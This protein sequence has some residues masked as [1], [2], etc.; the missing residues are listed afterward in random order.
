MKRTAVVA[1]VVATSMA[2]LA[3]VAYAVFPD[4]DVENYTGCLNAGGSSVG[5]IVNVAVGDAPS[6][7]CGHNQKVIHLGGGDI[8][9]TRTASGSGLKGGTENGAASLALDDTGCG[10]GGVLKW[11]GTGWQCGTDSDTTYSAGTGLDLTGSTFSVKSSFQLPQSCSSGQLTRWSG[12]DQ[13]WVCSEEKSQR[14][15]FAHVASDGALENSFGVA[16]ASRIAVGTYRVEFKGEITSC[17]ATVSAGAA[18]GGSFAPTAVGTV[19]I[20]TG[21][22]SGLAVAVV[23]FTQPG[24]SSRMD[25]D[26]NLIVAC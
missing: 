3:G 13:K 16:S 24:G 4:S 21:S 9:A 12:I 23:A 1:T 5:T 17:A 20:N 2:A 8:T 6:R 7:P 25:T 10:T 22:V 19:S 14:P 18:N 15:F 11:N 26:F